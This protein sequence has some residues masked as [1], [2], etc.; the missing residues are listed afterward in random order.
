MLKYKVINF[1]IPVGSTP[2]TKSIRIEKGQ[3][4]KCSLFTDDTPNTGV[5]IKIEE[6]GG[7][8]IHPY[9]TYKE[10]QPTNGNH[11]DSRKDLVFDGNRDINV[12]AMPMGDLEAPFNFQMI[13][14]IEQ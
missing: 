3:V 2:V 5:N 13:F 8:D 11:L 14:Y 6:N 4:E 12:I 9:V 1:S 10:F 7:D